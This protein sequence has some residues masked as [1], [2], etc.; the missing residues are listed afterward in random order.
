MNYKQLSVLLAVVTA[1]FF[2]LQAQPAFVQS[3]QAVPA[4]QD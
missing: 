1:S 4:N 3:Y 2:G